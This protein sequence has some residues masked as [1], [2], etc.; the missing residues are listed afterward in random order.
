MKY[1]FNGEDLSVLPTADELSFDEIKKQ[2]RHF[3]KGTDSLTIHKRTYFKN[4]LMYK[5]MQEKVNINNKIK[6]KLG[7]EY[8]S[9]FFT[10]KDVAETLGMSIG[11]VKHLEGKVT[12]TLKHPKNTRHFKEYLGE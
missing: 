1:D 2:I 8:A 11:E 12:R 5:R 9:G 6:R 3:S 7:V 4:L 10:K